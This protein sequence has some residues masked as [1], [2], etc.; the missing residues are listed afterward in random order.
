MDTRQ[1]LE[2]MK[3]T[4]DI[5]GRELTLDDHFRELEEW[6]SL[7]YLM[8]IS[9]IDDE[10]GIIISAADFRELKTLGDIARAIEERAH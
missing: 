5:E 4:L 6:S 2:H 9:M 7:A 3:N 10:Y 8:T 1:F